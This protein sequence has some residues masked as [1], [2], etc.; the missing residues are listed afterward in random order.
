[1]KLKI[2]Y[3][4]PAQPL[5]EEMEAARKLFPFGNDYVLGGCVVQPEKKVDGFLCPAC[6]KAR[7]AWLK[8]HRD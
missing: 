7:A 2:V 3:G 4:L 5:M 8:T 6:V 1:V